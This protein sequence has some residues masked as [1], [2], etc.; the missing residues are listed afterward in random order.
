MDKERFARLKSLY[1]RACQ[2]PEPERLKFLRRECA[3]D[4]EL[5]DESCALLADTTHPMLEAG[6]LGGVCQD[7]LASSI[8][9]ADVPESLG[10]YRILEVL[11]AGGMGIVLRAQQETPIRREVAVKLARG[12]SIAAESILH[13]FEAE[14]QILALMEHPNIARVLDAGQDKS[15]NPY[16][17]MDLVRG[18]PISSFCRRENLPV[19]K[20]IELF[21]DVC[22][23]IQHAH[24]KGIIHRDIKPSNILVCDREGTPTPVVIDFGIAKAMEAISGH[25]Q[26]TTEGQL[27]GT[28]AYMSPE[29]A[30]GRSSEVDTRSD[31]YSLGV[32]LYE[33]VTEQLPYKLEELSLIEQLKAVAEHTPRKFREVLGEKHVFDADLET[34][35]GKAL[36]KDPQRR[37]DSAAALRADLERFLALRPV[38]ARPDSTMYQLRKLVQRHRLPTALAGAML[39]LLILFGASMSV[40]FDGQRRA[41]QRVEVTSARAARTAGFLERMLASADADKHGRDVTVRDVLDEAAADIRT[42]LAEEPEVRAAV[43]DVIGR[44]YFGLGVYDSA[45]IHLGEALEARRRLLPPGHPDIAEVAEHLGTLMMTVADYDS[46]EALLTQAL[47]LRQA[48]QSPDHPRVQWCLDLIIQFQ[49]QK[50][51]L[52]AAEKWLIEADSLARSCNLPPT[53]LLGKA[54]PRLFG[55]VRSKQGRYDEAA[56]FLRTAL[57]RRGPA[58]ET[59]DDGTLHLMEM[60]AQNLQAAG[61]YDE[62]ESLCRRV[63]GARRIMLGDFHPKVG[64]ALTSLGNALNGQMRSDDAREAFL[65][66]LEVFTRALGEHHPAVGHVYGSLGHVA[67]NQGDLVEAERND[68]QRLRIQ[69]QAVGDSAVS[70]CSPMLNLV[71]DLRYLH[72]LTEADSLCRHALCVALL[73]GAQHTGLH[74]KLLVERGEIAI[75]RGRAGEAEADL[76]EALSILRK[77]L[78]P[79]DDTVVLIENGLGR[80]LAAQGRFDEASKLLEPSCEAILESKPD[81][82]ERTTVLEGMI[83]FYERLK[84]CPNEPYREMLAELPPLIDSARLG[85]R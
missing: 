15:G 11:G 35:V 77:L 72:R 19:Q 4:Q 44:S 33:L 31:T 48:C 5:Y 3:D 67:W 37:Y 78:P 41:R 26:L 14:S 81:L 53:S 70:L 40:L 79:G 60:L 23:A 85:A 80:C 82:V 36:S 18:T 22:Q 21:L 49:M 2:L 69:H 9:G 75:A 63:V 7:A 1:L 38:L 52:V 28:V 47:D 61:A 65:E 27:I 39:L 58:T 6:A 83:S 73:H 13:R 45:A 51:D 8:V 43:Q 55:E 34:I 71:N 76:R 32:V 30:Q 57:E 59:L 54:L 16:F 17:V 25:S 56:D 12:V 68:R 24:Q 64:T 66:A 20:R 84:T 50:G 10:P 62:S 29:Q 42:G 74:G 46:A